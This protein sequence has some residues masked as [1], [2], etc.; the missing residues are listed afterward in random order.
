MYGYMTD[1][2]LLFTHCYR[3]N[4]DSTPLHLAAATG[5]SEVVAYLLQQPG[6]HYVQVGILQVG[7]GPTKISNML[8]RPP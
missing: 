3:N 7:G 8:F 4:F 5:H 1:E 6:I 2:M